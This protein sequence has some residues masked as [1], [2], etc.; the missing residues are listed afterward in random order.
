VGQARQANQTG[1]VQSARTDGAYP[2]HTIDP[3][4]IASRIVLGIPTIVS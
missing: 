1:K 3:I 4:V 2:Q